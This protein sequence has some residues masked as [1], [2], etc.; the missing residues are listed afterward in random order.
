LITRGSIAPVWLGLEL[1]DIDSAMQEVMELGPGARGALIARV[2]EGSSAAEAALSR[3]ELI[4]AFDGVPVRSAR[5]YYDLLVRVTA[6]QQV[7]LTVVS[8]GV[9]REVPVTA[10]EISPAEIDRLGLQRLGMELEP[11]PQ[12][13]FAVVRVVRGSGAAR[14]G[15]EPGDVLLGINGQGLSDADSLRRAV[16]S[17]RGRDGALLVVRRGRGRYHLRVPLG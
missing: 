5:E 11:N 9:S 15:I 10:R 3:G 4:T 7:R 8:N 12:G 16:L 1:Q 2:L 6:G 17:T 13:G 14:T